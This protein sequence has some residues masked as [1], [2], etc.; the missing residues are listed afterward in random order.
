MLLPFVKFASFAGI[1]HAKTTHRDIVLLGNRASVPGVD[2]H[3]PPDPAQGRV[4][5]IRYDDGASNI[6]RSVFSYR[7][8]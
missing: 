6:N 8:D 4:H 2:N 3:E 1:A 5:R 7:P